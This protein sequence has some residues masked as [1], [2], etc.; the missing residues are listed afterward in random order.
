MAGQL[1]EADLL[2]AD[3]LVPSPPE[4]AKAFR[5][6][7]AQNR[8]SLQALRPTESSFERKLGFARKIQRR[9]FD[10]GWVRY[11][12]PAE[13]GGL[14]GTAVH[15]AV[16]YNELALAG[17]GSRS[18]L[19]HVEVLLPAIARHW[20]PERL[21]DLMPRFLAADELWCQGFSEPGAGS[22]LA[23]LRTKADRDGDG[24][25]INGSKIWT[26]WAPYARRCLLLAR[27]GTFE[28][29]HRGLSMFVIDMHSE[30]IT[31]NPIRQANGVAELAEVFF[32]NVWIEDAELVGKEGDGWLVAMDVL[33]CERSSFAWLR[34]TAL[35]ERAKELAL[36]AEEY[37][38]AALGN[39][40]LD[41]LA[42]R[43][44]SA[45]N[46]EQL[47]L[48]QF[49]G[50]SAALTK[51]L[52]TQADQSLYDAALAVL[53][54]RLVLGQADLANAVGWQE[55]YMF[56]RATSIYGGTKE[57]QLLTVARFLLGLDSA[58]RS[59]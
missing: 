30:G 41:L 20:T 33:A 47:S 53:G 16:V 12:W 5:S 52:L 11:G 15:R 59:K 48:G 51:L 10:E 8:D 40:M 58:V 23:A 35:Y 27:T 9:L 37:D 36:S 26:S 3:K 31:V 1:E 17:L 21:I 49:P 4:L 44:S 57:M 7:L 46:V 19:E 50:P 45:A 22:D 32:D 25:R 14:G 13:L 18:A 6:W 34:Q 43:A 56:S 24:F 42:V 55:E 29:R 39:V 2:A 28:E 38:A 54:P